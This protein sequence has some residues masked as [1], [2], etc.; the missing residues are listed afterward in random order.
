MLLGA[1]D[2][3]SSLS[4]ASVIEEARILRSQYR[5]EEAAQLLSSAMD[6]AA[7][8]VQLLSELADCHFQSGELENA[9]SV[10]GVLSLISPEDLTCKVRLAVIDF[11]MRNYP[12]CI[13]LGREITKTDTIPSILSMLGD[14]YVQEQQPDSA[15]LH[16]EMSLQRKPRNATVVSKLA[17]LLVNKNEYK[18]VLDLTGGYLS[19]DPGNIPIHSIRGKAFYLEKEYWNSRDEFLFLRDSLE[20]DSYYTHLYLGLS[21]I[22]CDAF[23]EAEEELLKAWQRDSS[24][25]NLALSLAYLEDKYHYDDITPSL[26]WL[27]K[28]RDMLRPDPRVLYRIYYARAFGHYR[29]FEW[30]GAIEYYQKAIATDPRRYECYTALAY[31]YSSKK[32]FRSAIFW[33]ERFLK[34]AS[35]NDPDYELARERLEDVKREQFMYEGK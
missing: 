4:P 5:F 25:V 24:D 11:R 17:T 35:K 30:D 3:P 33:Y 10:Y 13:E 12:A 9:R 2:P 18:R 23:P 16:Y 14:A 21:L 34:V 7:P 31:C 1:Q 20:D 29:R 27:D 22:E 19:L 32:D 6:P 26:K 8:S 28:A 15:I